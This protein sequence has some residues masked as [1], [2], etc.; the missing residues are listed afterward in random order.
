MPQIV[1]K[2]NDKYEVKGC[3]TRVD[4]TTLSITELPLKTWTQNY[5]E[6]IEKMLVG[7]GKDSPATIKDFKENHTDTTVSFTI[8]AEKT[9]IDAF[10]QDKKGLYGVFKLTSS[11]STANMTL[12]D[13]NGKIVRY[14]TPQDILSSFF[15]IRLDFYIRRKESLVMKLEGEQ[16]MLSNK[17]RFVEAVC[18]GALVVSNRKRSDILSDLQSQGFDTFSKDDAKTSE[19]TDSEEVE[20]EATD[21]NLAKGYEYLLGMKIWS[22][23]YEKAESLRAQLEE[24]TQE[25]E[26]L[27]ATTPEQ[28]WLNDL[29]AI[30]DALR[31][32]DAEMQKAATNEKNAQKKSQKRQAKATKKK[33]AASR[34]KKK[35]KDEWD[36]EMETSCD[37]GNPIQDSDSDDDF[38][39]TKKPA[40]RPKV[41]ATKVASKKVTLPAKAHVAKAAPMAERQ[42][43]L[44]STV[45]KPLEASS[46][47]EDDNIGSSLGERLKKRLVVSPPTKK[48]PRREIKK[49]PSPK[50]YDSGEDM[51]D[52]EDLSLAKMDATKFAPA[53][54]TPATKKTGKSSGP[55]KRVT[56]TAAL[57]ES[58]KTKAARGKRATEKKA[59]YES[60]ED[61]FAFA[62][63]A[64]D[65]SP[66]K[67]PGPRRAR[68]A[69]GTTQR[70]TYSFDSDDDSY[71][72]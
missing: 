63:S 52:S 23:T 34:K 21:A 58:G 69:R 40:S 39:K 49:R 72:A 26:A 6:F 50:M 15:T 18:V 9:M 45:T 42:P 32:R 53:S 43:Q 4:D 44:G 16:R 48:P 57:A 59:V 25:L 37:E 68:R 66:I 71:G 47:S 33:A 10:E 27:N 14:E 20:M 35:K 41:P 65:S 12:F 19:E 8:T 30:E 60:S 51:G 28:L 31:E 36:S 29:D 56:N 61:E 64:D 2:T 13:S 5:K 54:L 11:I 7:D 55:L 70:V 3:I 24:K 22:L 67:K 38:F 1:P 62:E 17:A 46:E